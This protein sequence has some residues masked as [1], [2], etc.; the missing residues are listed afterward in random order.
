MRP[1]AIRTHPDDFLAARPDRRAWRNRRDRLAALGLRVGVLGVRSL[2]RQ[3]LFDVV[4]KLVGAGLRFTGLW[5]RGLRNALD[6]RLCEITLELPRLPLAFDGFRL[7]HV[8]DPHFDAT[9]GMADSILGAVRGLEIDLCVLTGDYR[10]DHQG[11]FDRVINDMRRLVDGVSSR[12][13]FLAT[14]GNHDE[15]AMVEAIEKLGIDV[16]VNERRYI[17]RGASRLTVTGIDDPH[18]NYSDAALAALESYDAAR[19]DV[20]L[21]LVHSPELAGAA[22]GA[23]HDLYLCGH[24]HGGQI[25]LPGGRPLITHLDRHPELCQGL[26]SVGRMTGYT[27]PGSGVS[28]LPVRFFSQGEVTLFTLRSGLHEAI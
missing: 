3:R 7:L 23:G 21:V 16:L 11:P 24:T 12:N 8:T 4:L 17:N 2:W 6:V 1:A 18:A 22:A 25:C 27:S 20:G 13:G 5:R 15:A 10:K 28:G 26:W 14:L 19:H 9:P